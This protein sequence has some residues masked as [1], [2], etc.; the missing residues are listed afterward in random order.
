MKDYTENNLDT[1][2]N[3]VIG[4]E[5]NELNNNNKLNNMEN[6][7]NNQGMENGVN[8]QGMEEAVN[9]DVIQKVK[10]KSQKEYWKDKEEQEKAQNDLE[11]KVLI[12]RMKKVNALYTPMQEALEKMQQEI[13]SE[14]ADE[15][16]QETEA[17][18]LYKKYA[19]KIS[20]IIDLINSP[21]EPIQ[22][23]WERFFPQ[24]ELCLIYGD[25]SCGKSMLM[26]CV[27]FAI[28]YG[29]TEYLGFKIGLPMDRRRVALAITE[30]GEHTTKT[31][32]QKQ[33]NYFEPLRTIDE[34]VFDL[35]S[36]CED[37]VI[38]TLKKRMPD[39]NYDV[40]LVDT[41]QDDILGSMNDNNVVREYLNQL[42]LLASK[43][44]TTMICIHHK[45]KYTLDKAPSKED[46]SGTRAFGDKPRAI[47]EMRWCV[48]ED[49]AVYFTPIKANYEDNSF[50]K[51]SYLLKMNTE[52]LTFDYYGETAPSDQIHLSSQKKDMTEAIKE[53]IIA[54]KF[55]NPTIRQTEIAELLREDFP[56]RKINQSQV[57]TILKS[58]KS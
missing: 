48:D 4:L 53:K 41:P 23:V 39:M 9:N 36:C 28:A 11:K 42:S 40:V 21:Y 46:L 14:K 52:T 38:E 33:N 20:S 26:R 34:P 1:N 50:L 56:D 31:L 16:E 44:N 12:E 35:I 19:G 45:R 43:Y 57:S 29:L 51:K 6:T 2:N 22:Y 25:S 54:Y 24:G 3:D 8:N 37:G 55:S 18:A 15:I 5:N 58:L 47:A 32:L 49:N 17:D 10:R 30:D 7:E 27:A 13:E